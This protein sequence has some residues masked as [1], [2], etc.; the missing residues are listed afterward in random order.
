[1]ARRSNA[2]PPGPARL[3]L[4]HLVAD[5]EIARDP[6]DL[7][8]V[9]EVEPA[10]PALELEKARRLGVDV[11]VQVVVLVPERVRGIEVL[12]ILDEIRAVEDA[13]A[14]V[15]RE[16]REPRAAEHAA[17]VAHRVVA[18][19]LLPRAA[20][21]GHRRA[22]DD[23]GPGVVGIGGR[24]H[25]GGPAALAIA[26]DGGLRA[27]RMELA[28]LAH[29]LLLGLAHVDQRLSGLG[30]AEEDDEVDRMARRGCA[31][32]TCESSLNPPMPGP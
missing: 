25:H 29:E 3:A 18:L 30:I 1:M 6:L 32:P 12:E 27:V 5:E 8:A 10:P 17:G 21:V 2:L 14:H 24:E 19:A 20:P 13:A 11:R 28:H 26:D 4:P 23:D 22:V 15:G 16:R 7:F 9:H 31:T